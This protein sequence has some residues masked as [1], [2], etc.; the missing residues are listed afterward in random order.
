M[1]TTD[2]ATQVQ[3][4][5]KCAIF[6][7]LSTA[8]LAAI[9]EIAGMRHF[10]SGSFIFHQGDPAD[11][12][13]VLVEGNVRLTQIN[14]EG[15]QII[16]HF[17]GPGNGLG[18]VAALGNIAYPLSA[19][20]VEPCHA[21][22]W[23]SEYIIQLIDRFPRLAVNSLRV[24]SSRF[25]E[26]QERYRELATER[27]EQRVARTL[28]RLAKQTGQKIDEG[29]RINMPLARRDLAEMTGTTLYTVSRILSNWEQNEL[30]KTGREQ[31]TICAPHKLIIIAED[32]P[33]IKE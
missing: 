20:A 18:I 8:D 16:V 31:I 14:A 24:L 17:F 1:I 12:F 23:S 22:I 2:I 25:S 29:I 6:K 9:L 10:L 5:G 32:L 30:V 11:A 3:L 28:M 33:Q 21:L 19:E 26:L 27:V 13:Y 4:L 7:G 15:H